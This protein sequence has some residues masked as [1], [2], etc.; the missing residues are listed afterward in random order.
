MALIAGYCWKIGALRLGLDRKR[1][2][3]LNF[4]FTNSG[5]GGRRGR[6]SAWRRAILARIDPS[7]FRTQTAPEGRPGGEEHHVLDMSGR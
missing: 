3:R 6:N 5:G 4:R 2:R 1:R 7:W